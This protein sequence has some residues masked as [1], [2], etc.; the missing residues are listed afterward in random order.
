M[1]IK[2]S[3]IIP[4]YN[5]GHKIEAAIASV[6]NQNIDDVEI[7]IVNDGSTD[8]TNLVVESLIEDDLVYINNSRNL[9]VNK[10]MN[11]GF[12]ASKGDYVCVLAADDVFPE[13]SLS[14]R[15]VLAVK[16][17]YD[18][19]HAGETVILNDYQYYVQPLDT[20]SITNILEFLEKGSDIA[21]INNATFMYNRRV[22]KDIGYRDE[23]DTYFPHND[24]EFALRT[25]LNC[26]VGIV[27]LP[28][29]VYE[30][31]SNSHSDIHARN[32]LAEDRIAALKNKYTELFKAKL[33]TSR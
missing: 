25:L 16:G 31:H 5:Y 12:K 13:S 14:S 18:A 29:Y 19:V 6:R 20:S 3:V 21:G 28:V 26:N 10:T 7:I 11:I 22:F 27:D 24:Y 2:I 30:M 1:A 17:D 9:G 33:E 15:Y 32:S 4:A 23:T 8:N